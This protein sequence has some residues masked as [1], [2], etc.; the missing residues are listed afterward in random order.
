MRSVELVSKRQRL[1]LAIGLRS[2]L[3]MLT[4]DGLQPPVWLSEFQRPFDCDNLRHYVGATLVIADDEG[5]TSWVTLAR[6]LVFS[7]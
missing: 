1:A 3:A 7:A 5:D 2:F 6:R 4:K